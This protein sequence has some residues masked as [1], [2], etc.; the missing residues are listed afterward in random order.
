VAS[1]RADGTGTGSVGN[2]PT[3]QGGAGGGDG[4]AGA[5]PPRTGLRSG[6]GAVM[7]LVG[8]AAAFVAARP[9]TDNSFL[10]HLATGRLIL[11]DGLPSQNPFLFTG[12]SFPVP[13]WWWSV[14]LAA[15]E[16][17][18][19]ATS[20]RLLTAA[21]AFAAGAALVR[22]TRSTDGASR[23]LLASVL[24]AALALFCVF[25]FLSGRPHL[26][27]FLLLALA[28]VVWNEQRSPWWLVPVFAI[29]VNVHGSWLYGVVVL[30]LFGAARAIDDRR[31]RRR[32]IAAVGAAVAGLVL[33][34]ALYPRAFELVLL[35]TRQFGDPV[36]R[37][38]LSAYR[39]WARV[40]PDQP[41]LW[42]LVVLGV[43]ALVGAVRQRRWASAAVVLAM[44]AMGWS[45][46]RLVPIAAISLVPF[47]A[48]A[49][50]GFGTLS[51][52]AGAAVR[53]CWFAAAAVLTLTVVSV[54]VTPAYR[55]DRYPVEAVDWLEARDLVASDER[56]LSHDYVGNYLEW[57][58]GT[59][60]NAYVD[61][62]PDAATLVQYRTIL[63][64]EPGWQGELASVD[65]QV[66]LWSTDSPLTGELE[67]DRDWVRAAELGDYTVFCRAE[68]AERCR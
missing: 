68:L 28:L 15:T 53:R 67:G 62:R 54:L 33:G 12:T 27:G 51:L 44:V 14:L 16:Q 41:M 21:V 25:Q 11:A 37:E 55:M 26:A 42:A 18:G 48:A 61:D 30:G 52:P 60:A 38:A 2:D 13:S 19:G 31:L 22:L 4:V 20:I 34:G 29:W 45:G 65:P 66:V 47:A 39:E 6:L 59:R 8:A 63:R 50:A 35:P 57:R 46:A 32:D 24:P 58:Y 10:T 49:M 40:G 56:V 3:G 64:L 36:E 9:L 7:V 1:D 43:V 23:S 5:R 17:V